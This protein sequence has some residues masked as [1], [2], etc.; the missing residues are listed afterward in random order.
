M[1]KLII[2]TAAVALT[3]AAT[4]CEAAS[5]ELV[6]QAAPAAAD[7]ADDSSDESEDSDDADP[8]N[9]NP[10][11]GPY[12]V[13]D[14]V[15]MG[16]LEHTMHGARWSVG[17]EFFGPDDDERWLVVDIEVTNTGDASEAI[18]SLIMWTLVDADNRSADI[19]LT[20]DEQ[21][22]LDGELGAGRSMR[23]ETAFSVPDDG[24]DTW[25]LLF[26][27][28]VFGSGQAIYVI[29]SDDVNES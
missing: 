7:E 19:T 8:A 17:D 29:T 27:P 12:Q 22:S 3:L 23:G 15:A 4:G 2:A 1:R 21:G 16:D 25:Q 10:A 13:G 20:A 24:N 9:Q 6:D 5:P 18:S 14:T 26:E 11:D 28:N